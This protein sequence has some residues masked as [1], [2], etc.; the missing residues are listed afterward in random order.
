MRIKPW[1]EH[2]VW[3]VS[4]YGVF[5]GPF[6]PIFELNTKHGPEKTTYLDSFHAVNN[7]RNK[8]YWNKIYTAVTQYYKIAIK[9]DCLGDIHMV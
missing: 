7:K 1:Y 9:I 5:P 3:K 8:I 4:K 6:F 2:T